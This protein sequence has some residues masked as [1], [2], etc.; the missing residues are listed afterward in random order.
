MDIPDRDDMGLAGYSDARNIDCMVDT[1]TKKRNGDCERCVAARIPRRIR[2]ARYLTTGGVA[3]PGSGGRL[4]PVARSRAGARIEMANVYAA[5][6]KARW[7][8]ATAGWWPRPRRVP[9]GDH[10]AENG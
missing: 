1:W 9:E 2:G 5:S 4:R 6:S 8:V 10:N 7:Q 3:R